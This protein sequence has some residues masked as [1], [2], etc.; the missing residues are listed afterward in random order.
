[1]ATIWLKDRPSKMGIIGTCIAFGGLF[2]LVGEP[3]HFDNFWAIFLMIVSCIMW[4]VANI[5]AKKLSTI[6]PI[7]LNASMA[8]FS[9]FILMILSLIFETRQLEYFLVT[10]WRL[11]GS[12]VYQVLGATIIAYWVWYFLMSRYQISQI[13]GFILLVPFFGVISGIVVLGEPM[14]WR[15]AVGGIITLIGVSIIILGRSENTQIN[16]TR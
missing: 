8:I 3:R 9:G 10:D 4:A 13:A 16:T 6:K 15:T 7:T 2:V 5:Q 14:T 1:M 11:H 12:L